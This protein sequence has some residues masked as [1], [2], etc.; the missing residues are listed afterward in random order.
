MI[1]Q[2]LTKAMIGVLFGGDS[3][4]REISLLSGSAVLAALQRSGYQSRAVEIASPDDLIPGLRG[5]E[6]VFIALHGGRGENGEIQ[7]LLDVIGIPYTGSSAQA[8]ALA[9]N[10]VRAKAIFLAAGIPTPRHSVYTDG[11]LACWS[12]EIVAKLNLPI[13]LKPYDQGS[14]IG[15]KL[16][17]TEEEV[18][19]AATVI[20]REFGS[21]FAEELI[22]GRELTIG[23]LSIKGKDTALPVLEIRP[24]NAFY[25]YEA[26]YVP[27]KAEFLLPAP[28]PPP[29]T[30][31]VQ[32]V[33]LKAHNILGCSGFSR[34]DLR[35]AE[36]GTPYVLEVNTIPGMTHRSNLTRAALAAGI[37]YTRLVELMLATAIE[38]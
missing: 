20:L 19:I 6:I 24:Q 2:R 32:Q 14:S 27:G 16:V 31:Y 36:D 12:K 4:E 21:L 37:E 15:V 13:V 3:T 26:K 8:N 9:I 7:G 34:V 28:L 23:I 30:E 10:K 22:I 11:D 33:S 29:L 17:T 25:S 35:L 5:I 18:K 1:E 38:Q